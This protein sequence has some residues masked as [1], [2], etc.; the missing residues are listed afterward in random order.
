MIVELKGDEIILKRYPPSMKQRNVVVERDDM[1]KVEKIATKMD[2]S[3]DKTVN[4][5]LKLALEKV[6]IED[7]RFDK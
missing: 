3:D 4:L 2:M 6:K 1:K 5:L 7:V